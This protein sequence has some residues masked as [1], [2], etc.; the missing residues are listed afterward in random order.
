MTTIGEGAFVLPF[1]DELG[2]EFSW[3]ELML[4]VTASLPLEVGIFGYFVKS[5]SV[6]VSG[7][8]TLDGVLCDLDSVPSMEATA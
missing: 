1:S 4:T 8:V 7:S 6:S 3:N 2:R 5:T